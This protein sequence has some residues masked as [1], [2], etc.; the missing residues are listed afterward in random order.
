MSAASTGALV[1]PASE[2]ADFARLSGD[3]NPLHLDDTAARRLQF[4]GTVCH[5][6]HL[7]LKAIDQA[8][9]DGLL[10]RRSLA[11]VSA[12][13]QQPVRTGAAV[14]LAINPD[15]LRQRIRIVG[16]IEG[17]AHFT[18]Q[19]VLDGADAHPTSDVA[20]GEPEALAGALNPLFPV[21]AAACA[22]L[23]GDVPLRVN[24]AL[25]E[26]LLPALA[27]HGQGL[28]AAAELLAT[29]RVVGMHCPGLNSIYSELKLRRRD[30]PA[31]A[32]RMRYRVDKCDPRF[33]KLRLALDG[34]AFEGVLEAF[35]RSPPVAQRSLTEV[36]ALTQP[37][38]VSAQKALVVGGSRGL[39]ELVAKML[40][41]G[42]A[43]VTLT[44]ARGHDDAQRVVEEARAA[45]ATASA[46][47]LDVGQALPPTLAEQLAG[48]AFTHLYFFATPAI[49]RSAAGTWDPR[50]F[51][52]YC[53]I[54]VTGF[55]EVARAVA[56]ARTAAPLKVLYPSTVFLDHAEKGFAEYCAAK[57][58]GEILCDHLALEGR[59]AVHRPRLPRMKTDQNSSFLGPQGDDPL[60]TMARTLEQFCG[61]RAA[62]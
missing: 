40:L 46:L 8:A 30:V 61:Y 36:V 1:I 15:T 4:G 42:G 55:T 41:A 33:R 37:G 5:G 54:Y 51:E 60:P 3:F 7:V 16:S 13:F 53:R 47:Q 29:T 43:A 28:V 12:V 21:D 58:A 24:R 11:A 6:V 57:A 49:A 44:Y 39:G 62:S 50:L 17:R 56:G 18:V 19:L 32:G 25:F 45:G 48:E 34:A 35:F 23:A 38:C 10:H 26:R 59:H 9:R 27:A 20:A 31:V 52:R 22:A 2:S 14:H